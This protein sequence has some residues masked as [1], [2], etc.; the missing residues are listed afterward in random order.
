[1]NNLN[2]SK[3]HITPSNA[4][5]SIMFGLVLAA[6]TPMLSAAPNDP[7]AVESRTD[8][9]LSEVETPFQAPIESEKPEALSGI[10]SQFQQQLLQQ[11]VEAL[12]GLVEE[13]ANEI[14]RLKQTG[15]DRYL[16]LD[17]RFQAL[18]EE[19]SSSSAPVVV[20]PPMLPVENEAV[21][22]TN[23]PQITG[24][25]FSGQSECSG[26]TFSAWLDGGGFGNRWHPAAASAASAT[27]A[28]PRRTTACTRGSTTP[29]T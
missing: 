12:R 9:R 8:D 4:V 18:V 7:V 1:M 23:E 10:E 22:S 6:F 27:A 25:G 20:K 13:L 16:E 26:L 29:S 2:K 15:D 5:Y 24:S 14:K 21:S 19:V 28:T 11:E 3:N 17:G